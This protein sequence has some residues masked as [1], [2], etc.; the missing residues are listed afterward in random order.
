M[1]CG[2]SGSTGTS[3]P[4]ASPSAPAATRTHSQRWRTR[5]ASTR[6]SAPAPRSARPRLRRTPTSGAAP[7]RARACASAPTSARPPCGK[8]V[9]TPCACG[10]TAPGSSLTTASSGRPAAAS[11]TS[12]SAGPTASSPTSS[13][14]SSMTL[15]SGSARS[16][17]VPTSRTRPRARSSSPAC[18]VSRFLATPT[19]RS[20]SDRIAP[21]SP[22]ATA[23]RPWPT[24]ASRSPRPSR[25][26]PIRSGS[27]RD[28]SCVRSAAELL[29]EFDPGRIPRAARGPAGVRPEVRPVRPGWPGRSRTGG[30]RC[31]CLRHKTPPTM[32]G[33]GG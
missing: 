27:P 31:M 6:A 12:S 11:T 2:R 14:S 23:R 30:P 10:R 5:A 32:R 19:S 8:A 16:C 4:F 7:T 33:T 15:R 20:S 3:L 29:P 28:R 17:A 25:C 18:S 22:S 13:P 26:S 1:T 24:A 21:A 9:P